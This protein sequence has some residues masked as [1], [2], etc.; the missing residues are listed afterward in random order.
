MRKSLNIDELPTTD[1]WEGYYWCSDAQKP[2]LIN[3]DL[4]IL[5]AVLEK[6]FPFVVEGHVAN[7]RQSISIRH[8]GQA[9]EIRQYELASFPESQYKECAYLIRGSVLPGREKVV[10]RDVWEEVP[11]EVW[12]GENWQTLRPSARVFVGFD[13][14]QSK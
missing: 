13:G 9:H 11:V 2:M 10:F 6:G 7:G 14:K 8:N 12:E 1:G 3:G 5:K 4:F